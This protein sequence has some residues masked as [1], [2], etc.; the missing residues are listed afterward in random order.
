MRPHIK[1]GLHLAG[2]NASCV[3]MVK[4]KHVRLALPNGA[5]VTTS[6]TPRDADTAALNLARDV[7]RAM[8]RLS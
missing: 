4:T 6:N 1:K 5:K 8:G 7:R 2:L 3:S